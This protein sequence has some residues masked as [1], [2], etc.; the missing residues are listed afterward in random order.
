M[1]REQ[2]FGLTMPLITKADGTKFGK[3]ESGTIW[4]DPSKTSP[5]AFYQFWL[6]T[7][8][9]DVYKFLR[10]FTFLPIKQ[11]SQIEAD[12]AATQGRPQAQSVLAKEVTRLVHRE[13]GLQAA[14]RITDALFRGDTSE[15]S[16]ND[17]KQLSQD[18]LPSSEL[19]GQDL[20]ETP[21]TSLLSTAGMGAGKQVKD[22]LQR[23][24]VHI[25][26]EAYGIEDNWN[27][28]DVFSEDK[29]VFGVYYL[30]K[31]GK[32]KHHLFY[33]SPEFRVK[34]E[35]YKPAVKKE[36]KSFS[37]WFLGLFK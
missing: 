1:N 32:K 4:L 30:V 7:A 33:Y 15:L 20:K 6:N 21:L 12:D 3:T 2:V 34:V 27:T 11:I 28:I 13:E 26:G 24:A 5:Y 36:R 37:S 8:D 29:G 17:Y 19:G 35:T 10:Y 9:A 18:G 23:K 25:N 14:R 22:A 31:V 16:K